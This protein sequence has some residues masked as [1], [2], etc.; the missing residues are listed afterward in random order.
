MKK[1]SKILLVLVTMLL[2]LSMVL[3]SCGF[4]GGILGGDKTD[5]SDSKGSSDVQESESETEKV[6]PILR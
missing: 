4:L 2:M 6:L 3:T 1:I 5:E